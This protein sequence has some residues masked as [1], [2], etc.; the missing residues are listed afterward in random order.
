MSKPSHFGDEG[1]KDVTLL[2]GIIIGIAIGIT[3]LFVWLALKSI[4][5]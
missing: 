1:V 5:L 4:V 2:V 3:P